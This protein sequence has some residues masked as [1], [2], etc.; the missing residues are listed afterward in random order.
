M[1]MTSVGC[2]IAANILCR[3]ELSKIGLPCEEK[4]EASCLSMG[5]ALV[6][7]AIPSWSHCSP[8]FSLI[9]DT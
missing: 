3:V 7:G 6:Y 9:G 2:M 1:A 8:A 4:L 5:S